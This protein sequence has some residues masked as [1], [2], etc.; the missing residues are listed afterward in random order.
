MASRTRAFLLVAT[1]ALAGVALRDA[2]GDV[3]CVKRSGQVVER[4]AC[5]KRERAIDETAVGLVGPAG[6]DGIAGPTGSPGGH[7]YRLVDAQGHPFGLVLGFDTA[8]VRVEVTLPD[9]TPV[10]FVVS[11]E[12]GFLADV[13]D[14]YYEEPGCT[15]TPFVYGSVGLVPP[16]IVVGTVGYYATAAPDV[17]EHKS[18]ESPSPGSCSS[19]SV[20]T[21]RGTCCTD[22]SGSAA[23]S[24]AKTIEI[25]TLGVTLPFMVQR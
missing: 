14:V 18:L 9:G 3:L 10:Q 13:P 21:S 20:A 25:S 1:V 19:G 12:G 24:P 8:R 7:P 6:A 11:V 15:G 5:R 2:R 22:F 23:G 17:I 16:V 4:T